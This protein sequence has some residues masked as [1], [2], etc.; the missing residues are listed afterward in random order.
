MSL[1]ELAATGLPSILVPYPYAAEDHQYH[2]AKVYDNAWAAR[3]VRQA[4][5]EQFDLHEYVSRLFADPEQLTKM[6][7]AAKSLAD[8]KASEK[9]AKK[10]IEVLKW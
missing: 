5:L 9:I 3:V 4:E 7:E 10:I 2:N 6:S 1:S 8:L